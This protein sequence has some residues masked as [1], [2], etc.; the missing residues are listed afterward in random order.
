MSA[1]TDVP[2]VPTDYDFLPRIADA[3]DIQRNDVVYDLGCG[4]GRLLF[5]CAKRNPQA[6]F[7]GI[8]RNPLLVA[9]ISVK[10]FILRTKNVEIRRKNFLEAD[11]SDATRIFVFLLPEVMRDIAPRLVAP[12]TV[13][14]AFEI[15][16]RY[17]SREFILKDAP[18][19]PGNTYTVYVYS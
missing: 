15:P 4:D 10:K 8:E 16:Q 14:R 6:R 2:Y 7:I 17:A 13:S 11:F 5:Y 12:R 3:L 19:G 18:P 1:F 9:F